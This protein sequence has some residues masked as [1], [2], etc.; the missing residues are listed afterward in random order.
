MGN[1][2]QNTTCWYF[3]QEWQWFLLDSLWDVSLN[4]HLTVE[5]H[6]QSP[7]DLILLF[8]WPQ[9]LWHLDIFR[10]SFRQ[11][12]THKCMEDSCIFCALKVSVTRCF[13]KKAQ[14]CMPVQE[15]LPSQK[16]SLRLQ[17]S[18]SVPKLL[19]YWSSKVRVEAAWTN[20]LPRWPYCS[21]GT[22]WK[23][24]SQHQELSVALFSRTSS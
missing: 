11:L 9:V 14:L 13:L 23:W 15:V 5:F 16:S 18:P 3:Q 10:R 24:D 17:E 8:S 22:Q 2:I 12:N 6:L 19:V 7:V 21:T 20:W 1:I 4:G